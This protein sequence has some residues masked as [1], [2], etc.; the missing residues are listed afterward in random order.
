MHRRRAAIGAISTA[1]L[2]VLVLL[3]VS[4]S[5][6]LP[7]PA[8]MYRIGVIT[9]EPDVILRQ[10]LREL[11]YVEGQSITFES[12]RILKGA[13]PDSLPIDSRPSTSWWSTPGLRRR[14]P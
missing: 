2:G 1:A 3:G 11:G 13:N 4:A 7:Q 6:A 9:V 14:L 12:D 5:R 10:S 8:R